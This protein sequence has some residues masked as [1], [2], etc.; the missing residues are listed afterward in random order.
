MQ[1]KAEKTRLQLI[2]ELT[3][4]L[5]MCYSGSDVATSLS[6]VSLWVPP[7][8]SDWLHVISNSLSAL[9]AAERQTAKR[10][11]ARLRV[12]GKA[13]DFTEPLRG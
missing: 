12:E 9:T 1:R 5:K 6:V 2:T 10:P 11:A 7:T 13:A 3:H 4:H 8:T